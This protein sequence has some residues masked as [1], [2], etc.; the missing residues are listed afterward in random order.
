MPPVLSPPPVRIP[1]K[2]LE[3]QEMEGFV[4]ELINSVYQI[5]FAIGG[6]SKNNGIPTI[7]FTIE[8]DPSSGAAGTLTLTGETDTPT[9]DPG[10]A[11]SSTVD[12]SAPDGYLKLYSGT[13]AV[14]V[15]FWNT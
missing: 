2:I 4:R 6:N 14:V 3:D 5:F 12:M 7:D 15:P 8:G 1:K 11:T 13:Q 10:W 9:S